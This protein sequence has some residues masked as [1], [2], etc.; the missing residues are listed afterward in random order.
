M[1]MND[2][3]SVIQQRKDRRCGMRYGS[4]HSLDKYGQR[5]VMIARAADAGYPVCYDEKSNLTPAQV[6]WLMT[7][8][9]KQRRHCGLLFRETTQPQQ[10]VPEPVPYT[11]APN[12]YPDASDANGTPTKIGA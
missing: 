1:N 2:S 6:A 12:T 7:R 3:R 4:L 8:I 5:R 9:P 10:Q 11:Q